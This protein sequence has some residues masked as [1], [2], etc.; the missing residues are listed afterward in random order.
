MGGCRDNLALVRCRSL[1]LPL[2]PSLSQT[3]PHIHMR[4]TYTT[5]TH[6]HSCATHTYIHTC[7]T[8]HIVATLSFCLTV[9][10]LT[11]PATIPRTTCATHMYLRVSRSYAY[12]LYLHSSIG[13]CVAGVQ[14]HRLVGASQ[15]CESQ[16][17]MCVVGCHAGG[18]VRVC[19]SQECICVIVVLQCAC[20]H[21]A[22]V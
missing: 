1:S 11:Q 6:Q 15:V 7:D 19:G 13:V 16:E 4:H 21:L 9:W 2:F 12:M 22:A 8:T 18:Y 20:V 17:C 5:L 14:L 3:H 10:S